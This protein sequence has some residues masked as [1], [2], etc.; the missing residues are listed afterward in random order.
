MFIVLSSETCF[1]SDLGRKILEHKTRCP[2]AVIKC[3][4]ADKAKPANGGMSMHPGSGLHPLDS[5]QLTKL[6]N[7]MDDDIIDSSEDNE[8]DPYE[9]GCGD[10]Y[11]CICG[12]LDI[13][14]Y[15]EDGNVIEPD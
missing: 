5:Q 11:C 2:T 1:D 9:S 6:S 15:D 10:P 12:W 13:P 7:K 4:A 3:G 8:Y 14:E